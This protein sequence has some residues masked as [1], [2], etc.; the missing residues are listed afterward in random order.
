MNHVRNVEAKKKLVGLLSCSKK[1]SAS[2]Q[3]GE[4]KKKLKI[5]EKENENVYNSRL[6]DCGPGV[7]NPGQL[8]TVGVR[9]DPDHNFQLTLAG[10]WAEGTNR[11]EIQL[12]A[13]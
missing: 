1:P 11:H 2:R 13:R 8:A 12:S 10:D 4:T 3:F 6:S 7:E 5:E 9:P